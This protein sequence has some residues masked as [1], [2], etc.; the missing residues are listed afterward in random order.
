MQETV[1]LTFIK[2]K[3]V[4]LYFPQHFLFLVISSQCGIGSK[5]DITIHKAFMRTRPVLAVENTRSQ[6]TWLHVANIILTP[7]SYTRSNSLTS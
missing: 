6:C 5:N 2:N 1:K 7:A 4:P 3:S